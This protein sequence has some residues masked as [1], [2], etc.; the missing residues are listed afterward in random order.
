MVMGGLDIMDQAEQNLYGLSAHVP[1]LLQ[2]S[3]YVF[4][5][6]RFFFINLLPVFGKNRDFLLICLFLLITKVPLLHLIEF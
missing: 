1:Q 3:K 6:V 2:G 5:F 4:K